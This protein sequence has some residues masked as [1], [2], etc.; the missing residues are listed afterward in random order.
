MPEKA[1]AMRYFEDITV[2]DWFETG[3]VTVTPGMIKDFAGRYDPQPIHTDEEKAKQSVFGGLIA[4]GWHTAALTMKL[5]AEADPFNGAP[6]IGLEVENLKFL[7]PVRPGMRLS[8]RC[9]VKKG[10]RARSKPYGFFRV[11]AVTRNQEGE[12]VLSQTW[13]I[14]LPTRGDKRG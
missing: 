2:G 4:S 7:K 11:E 10:W 9:E 13:T 3:E 8:V 6:V 14:L 5:V 12:A 1:R